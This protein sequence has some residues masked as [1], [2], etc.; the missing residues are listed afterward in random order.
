MSNK[1]QLKPKASVLHFPQGP[2]TPKSKV[3]LR[4]YIL[5]VNWRW[6]EKE[7]HMKFYYIGCIGI[8]FPQLH[9][10]RSASKG[11]VSKIT[12]KVRRLIPSGQSAV[13]HAEQSQ[14]SS[15]LAERQLDIS[16]EGTDAK[17]I[18]KSALVDWPTVE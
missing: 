16:S 18:T 2:I 17:A 6:L 13:W 7:E 15:S 9:S 12:I 11:K 1:Y 8:S 3:R 10:L 5:Y 4:A 14:L